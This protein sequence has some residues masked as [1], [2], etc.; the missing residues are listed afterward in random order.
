MIHACGKK[1]QESTNMVVETLA[2]MEALRYCAH[3]HFTHIWLQTDSM[4]LKNVIE[5]N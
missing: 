4:M 1:I 3:H 2:I 5:A